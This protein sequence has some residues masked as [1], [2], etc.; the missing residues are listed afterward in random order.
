MGDAFGLSPDLRYFEYE[1]DSSEAHNSFSSGAATTDWPTFQMERPLS[2]IA[3]IKVLEVQIP[4]T[5]YI[6]NS[7]NNTFLFHSGLGFDGNVS[8]P[9]GNYNSASL[10]AALQVALLAVAAGGYV[11][12]FNSTTGKFTIGSNTAFSMVFGTS[13]DDG[14]SNLRLVLGFNPGTTATAVSITSPNVA[15]ITGPNYLYLC[16]D[17]L[18]TLIQLYLPASSELAQGGLGPEMAKIPIN[19]NPFGVITWADP[20]PHKY[21]D[22]Q[23]LFSLQQIDLYLTLGPSPSKPLKLN[24]QSFSVKLGILVNQ[25]AR[26]D[27]TVQGVI[28][29]R[30]E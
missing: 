28:K 11:V 8:I 15:A 26:T 3:G 21:F 6:V 18:G 9:V 14:L 1:F 25:L 7:Q 2:N 12:S 23:S 17:S 10:A 16:S 30:R 29:R 5:F 20:D 27:T 4:F 19:C 13:T 24:G 22:C